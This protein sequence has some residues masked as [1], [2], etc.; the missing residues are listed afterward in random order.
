[1]TYALRN[2]TNVALLIIR[3]LAAAAALLLVTALAA[4]AAAAQPA[5]GGR[6]EIR[7]LI[8]AFLPT[9]SQHDALEAAVI[10]GGQASYRVVRALAITASFAWSPSADRVRPGGPRL[11]VYQYDAGAELRA[12][13]WARGATWSLTPL[14]GAG[15]GGRTYDYRDLD[16]PTKTNFGGYGALGGELGFGRAGLRVEAR[17]YVTGFKPLE[18]RGDGTTRND[19][20]V[21]AGVTVR[22]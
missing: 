8:G 17:D 4:V 13:G 11:D 21:T 12:P 7:P 15:I 19:I 16:A 6:A 5:E 1:M 14:I 20:T 9:G 3:V 22:F 10:V 2:A 18:G